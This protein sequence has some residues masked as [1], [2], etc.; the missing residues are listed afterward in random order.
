MEWLVIDVIYIKS[1]RHYILTLHAAL[2][3]MVAEVLTEF[4]VNTGDVLSP[5]RGA[6]YLINNNEFQRLG[7][8]SASSFS[9]TL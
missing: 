3:K 4:P 6:E 2:L 8:F 7:L 5:V 9:A 1:T